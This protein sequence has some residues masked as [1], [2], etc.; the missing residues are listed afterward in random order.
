MPLAIGALAVGLAG[1]FVIASVDLGGLSM[2]MAH[3]I[4]LMNVF[5][6]LA[7]IMLASSFRNATGGRRSTGRRPTNA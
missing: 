1:T 6:P 5:A 2:H 4:A 3:H 7:A